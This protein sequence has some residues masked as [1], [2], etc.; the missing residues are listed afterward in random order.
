MNTPLN[1]FKN[2]YNAQHNSNKCCYD[3]TAEDE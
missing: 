1:Q 2:K 3:E